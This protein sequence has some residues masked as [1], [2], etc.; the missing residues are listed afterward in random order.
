MKNENSILYVQADQHEKQY[1]PLIL[2]QSAK[3]M[4]LIPLLYYLGTGLG[5]LKPSNVENIKMRIFPRV[6]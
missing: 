3:M 4:D 2:A 5:I 1:S 6:V